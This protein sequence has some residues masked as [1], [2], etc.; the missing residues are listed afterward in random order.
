V[1]Q[2]F[3]VIIER[4][5]GEGRSVALPDGGTVLI[6]RHAEAGLVLGDAQASRRH[7]ELTR[8]GDRVWLRDLDSANGTLLGDRRV[9]G[10]VEL[11]PGDAFVIGETTIRLAAAREATLIAQPG[12]LPGTGVFREETDIPATMRAT[13]QAGTG[14]G[15]GGV[16]N[17]RYR[18]DRL[19]G[20]GG[21]AQVFLATDLLLQRQVAVK[22]LHAELTDD[23]GHDFL[24]RFAQEARSVASLD[25]PNI[26]SIH[27]YGEAAGT[28]YLVMP[29][30]EGGTLHDLLQARGPVAPAQAASYLRQVAAALDY[31][32]RRKIV[33][34]DIKPQNMLIRGEDERL[35][36]SDFGIA[37]ALTGTGAQSRTSVMGTLSYMAPEQFDGVVS[38]A[39]DIYALGCV[40]YQLLTGAVPYS[41]TTEQVIF[42]HL[43]RPAPRL[44]ERNIAGL[45]AGVQGVLDRA[46]AKRPEDRFPSAGEFAAAYEG[47]LAG[48]GRAAAMGAA[49]VI[50]ADPNATVVG[51]GQALDSTVIGSG[52]APLPYDPGATVVGGPQPGAQV[53]WAPAVSNQYPQGPAMGMPYIPQPPGPTQQPPAGNRRAFLAGAAGLGAV[54]L[55]AAAGGGALVLRS[56][57]GA[58]PTATAPPAT[59]A[60]ANAGQGASAQPAAV[61]AAPTSAAPS[62]AAVATQP[63]QVP[64]LAPTAAPTAT[65]APPTATIAAPTVVPAAP[66]EAPAQPTATRVP[67]T[68]A[69]TARPTATS[70]PAATFA[71]TLAREMRGHVE[72]VES[73]AFSPDGT[74]LISGADDNTARVW[75]SN[76]ETAATLTGHRADVNGVAWSPNGTFLATASGDNTVRLWTADGGYIRDMT[77]HTDVVMAVAWHPDNI[78]L[79]SGS[80]DGTVR[81]WN[82]TSAV[83]TRTIRAHNGKIWAIAFAQG[84]VI[85]SG[86][87]DRAVKVWGIDGS[88]LSTLTGHGDVIWGLSFSP[89]GGQLASASKDGTARL[90]NSNGTAGATIVRGTPG[91]SSI[92]WSPNGRYIACGLYDG[93]VLVVTPGGQAVATLTGHS[94]YVASVAWHPDSTFLASAGQD[95]T[96]RVWG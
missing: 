3:S 22:V 16:L 4:G 31:A 34:R 21:F 40:L 24:A 20:R 35:L 74:R 50:G 58:D 64:T 61:S 72:L 49:T 13:G 45:P 53:G 96:I 75:R 19:I 66:T 82:S 29:Y 92:A 56:R 67:P 57:G 33:H 5:A 89:D 59:S 44:A 37:K 85:A 12:P 28:V 63:T 15:A 6:G 25:H 54:A 91:V 65:T 32:H 26:L 51:G 47:A 17:G 70:A 77:D 80:W 46:L 83:N 52:T 94:G 2:D 18:L 62:T 73:V 36:L 71:G 30:V 60:A 10:S 88:S 27:D 79:V 48:T 90:W 9:Q 38:P 93:R 39:T 76:G 8:Q 43:Q 7:A 69:P 42:S 55:I 84:S 1:G 14:T 11:R 78:T 81:V 95:A 23:Q 68:T 87:E 86:G 41:G